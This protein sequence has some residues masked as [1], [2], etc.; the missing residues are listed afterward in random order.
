MVSRIKNFDFDFMNF[1]NLFFILTGIISG[2]AL[3]LLAAAIGARKCSDGLCVPVKAE[4]ARTVANMQHSVIAST[5]KTTNE[6][7]ESS[8][9]KEEVPLI[10]QSSQKYMQNE[11]YYKDVVE[12][13]RYPPPVPQFVT[14]QSVNETT[15]IIEQTTGGSATSAGYIAGGGT[16]YNIYNAGGLLSRSGLHTSHRDLDMLFYS[17]NT[18]ADYELS[19]VTCFTM[20]PNGKYA[21]IGQSVGTPQIW[22]TINGQL[23]R[24][25]N[26][27]C[28]NCSNLELTCS[29]SLLVGLA[30]D[31]KG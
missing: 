22:D 20:T 10:Q 13:G 2:I 30:S 28:S 24:S 29:G 15:E 26:G 23:I 19:N 6:T 3:A 12:Y 7:Y 31:N 25:M 21:L 27:A 4:K 1:T 18:G 5:S 17:Q 14:T 9:R 16:A 11:D 8:M